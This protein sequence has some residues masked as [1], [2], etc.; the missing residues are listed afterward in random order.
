MRPIGIP[1]DWWDTPY[2]L[3]LT[4]ME[5]PVFSRCYEFGRV[6]TILNGNTFS[7]VAYY[8][9]NEIPAGE[10]VCAQVEMP[11]SKTIPIPVYGANAGV[12]FYTLNE[13]F[14]GTFTLN[15]NNTL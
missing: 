9:A 1:R 6:S 13:Q 3:L 10:L 7:E 8:K 4:Q 2:C 15:S 5:F 12:N 11:Y 14:T